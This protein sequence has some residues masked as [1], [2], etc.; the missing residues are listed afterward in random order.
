M[1]KFVRLLFLILVIGIAL[2]FL[3]PTA[4]DFET[5]V[6][7]EGV[8]QRRKAKG[9][10]IV[11]KIVDKGLTTATQLQLLATYRYTDHK[12]VALVEAN[13]NGDKNTYV[14]IATFWIS[15]PNFK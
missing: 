6:K 14:G 2:L 13:A 10:N 4:K 7:K 11:E 9:D 12:L 5:W 8:E 3:K 15:V 1:R